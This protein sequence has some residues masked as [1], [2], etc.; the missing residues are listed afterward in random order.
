MVLLICDI[1]LIANET[2]YNRSVAKYNEQQRNCFVDSLYSS[3]N[4]EKSSKLLQVASH[5]NLLFPCLNYEEKTFLVCW[6]CFIHSLR[7]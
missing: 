5:L 6:Y 1:V 3:L 4:F 2:M 7:Q